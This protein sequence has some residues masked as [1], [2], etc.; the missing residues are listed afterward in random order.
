MKNLFIFLLFMQNAMSS[1]I[2]TDDRHEV[3][4]ASLEIQKL[5]NSIAALVRKKNVIDQGDGTYKLKGSSYIE[6]LNFCSDSNFVQTQSLIANCS[7]F[8]VAPNLI[9]TAGHCVENNSK[10]NLKEFY[11]IF[12][13]KVNSHD[14]SEFII[15]KAQVFELV[16]A[17]QYI[18]EVPGDKD[19]AVIEL[20]REVKNRTPLK[21]SNTRPPVGEELY[22][23][24]FPYGLPMKYQDNGYVT[25]S[26]DPR[27]GIDSFELD[28]DVFSVNSGSA[29]FSARTNEIVGVLVRGSGP[30]QE[31]DPERKCD[32]W[33]G[34]I[35]DREYSGEGNYIDLLRF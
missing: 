29:I 6:N 7:A 19:I 27:G 33:G 9:G 22:I 23:L 17:K 1:I 16:S 8:L 26:T 21:L 28:L 20:D 30:N 10:I 13:Y 5:S 12:D 18:F 14:Q 15:K 2:G 31:T 32:V 24:G 4:D 34:E 3:I 25:N 35:S 11:A